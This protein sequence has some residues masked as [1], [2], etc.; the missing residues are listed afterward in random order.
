MDIRKRA[1]VS[2]TAIFL[3]MLPVPCLASAACENL[4][5][6]K[7]PQTTIK[8][9]ETIPAG[10]FTTSDKVTRTA[11]TSFCRV[12][13]SVQSAPDSDIGIEMWLPEEGWSGVFHGNGSGGYAGSFRTGYPEMETAIR[14]GYASAVTDMGTAPANDLDGDPLVGHPQKWKDWG[15][16]ST[17]VMTVTGKAIATSFYGAAPKRSYFTGCSTGGQQG[18]IEAQYYP[19]D[20]DGIVSGAPVVNRTWGHAAAVWAYKAAH[21]LP[22]HEISDVKLALLHATAV[23]ICGAKGNGLATDQFVGDPLA[24]KF[25]PA[26]LR[27]RGADSDSCLTDGEIATAR[28][29]YSGP[30]SRAEKPLYFGWLPGSEMGPPTWRFAQEPPINPQEPVFDGLFKWALGEHYDWRTFDFARDMATTDAVLGPSLNGA[31]KADMRAFQARGGR[32]VMY[33]GWADTL[34]TPNQTVAFYRKF[35]ARAGGIAKTQSFARLFMAAGVG[36][37]GGGDGPNSFMAIKIGGETLA[38]DAPDHDAF[39][40][41]THW[42]ESGEA[43]SQIIATKYVGNSP[44]KGVAMQRPLCPYPQKAWYK[45]FGSTNDAGNFVCAEKRPTR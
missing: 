36:H 22:G 1:L 41:M 26:I 13:A 7:L 39:A 33:Q 16:L 32:L 12:V 3:A 29:F 42:V 15:L 4:L 37:C 27:C 20:Y 18:L 11:P 5:A 38:S 34:V 23:K 28:A 17:H 6:L 35:A 45:G 44:A 21:L 43:P 31:A 9:A 25:D 10:N 24:C 14:R 8:S 40:A 30:M 19:D 2:T